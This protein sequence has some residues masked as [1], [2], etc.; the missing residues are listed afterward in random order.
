MT[1]KSIG[2]DGGAGRVL[3]FFRQLYG[4]LRVEAIRAVNVV[5]LCRAPTAALPLS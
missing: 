5:W 1:K 4:S 3:K 2:K